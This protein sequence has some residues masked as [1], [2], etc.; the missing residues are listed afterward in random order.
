MTQSKMANRYSPEVRARAVRMVF[1]H[2][3]SYETQAGAIAAIAPKIGC[4]PQTLRGWVRQAEKDSGLRDGMTSEE[5]ERIKALERENRELRQANDILR[6]GETI[7]RHWSED[8]GR[9]LF[10]RRRISFAIVLE[11]M[12]HQWLT[13]LKR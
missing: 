8:N 7:I 5:R 10:S 6:K 11:P 13:Q 4:I 3:G 2:Q 12:A 1:E 9:T